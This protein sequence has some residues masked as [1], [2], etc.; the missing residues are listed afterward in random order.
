MG[1]RTLRHTLPKQ[2]RLFLRQRVEMLFASGS[3]F[4]H[5][6]YRVVYYVVPRGQ[7]PL[8]TSKKAAVS[9]AVE[10]LI[11]IPKRK[12]KYATDRNRSKRITREVYRLHKSALCE[13]VN[14]QGQHLLLAL[15][16]VSDTPILFSEAN[17]AMEQILT[18]LLKISRKEASSSPRSSAP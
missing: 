11:S 16:Q 15:I 4:F 5:Y 1:I 18:R 9:P 12:L 13:A 10:L 8:P 7:T 2:E 14:L 3:H 6:P 17:K